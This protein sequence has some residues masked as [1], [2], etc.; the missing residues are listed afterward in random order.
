M[1]KIERDLTDAEKEMIPLVVEYLETVKNAFDFQ[2]IFQAW[3]NLNWYTLVVKEPIEEVKDVAGMP[4]NEEMLAH[5]QSLFYMTKSVVDARAETE[6]EDLRFY[7][8]LVNF[9]LLY[10]SR[11][12]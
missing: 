3:M 1:Q 11:S 4:V 7:A 6:V 9:M 5:A 2:D 8:W 12:N 10:N